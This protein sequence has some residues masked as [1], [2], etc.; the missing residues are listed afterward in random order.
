MKP[1]WQ[2]GFTSKWAN[3]YRQLNMLKCDFFGLKVLNLSIILMANYL[4]D[5]EGKIIT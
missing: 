5:R 2:F 1:A 4:L 3:F